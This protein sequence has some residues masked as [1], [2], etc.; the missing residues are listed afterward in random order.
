MRSSLILLLFLVQCTAR[1]VYTGP[2]QPVVGTCDPIGV[3]TLTLRSHAVEFAPSAG[4]LVLTGT[5]GQNGAIHAELVRPGSDKRPYRL[6]LQATL[7]AGQI[8]GD[9]VTPRCQ[10]KVHLASH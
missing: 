2:V 9:Y 8:E 4:V 7:A 5:L 3:G 6:T 1:A 10:Y